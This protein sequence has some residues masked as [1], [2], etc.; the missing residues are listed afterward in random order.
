MEQ[1]TRNRLALLVLAVGLVSCAI[2]Y[3]LYQLQILKGDDFRQLAHSQQ[4]RTM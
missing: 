2:G 3:R 4:R 1:A